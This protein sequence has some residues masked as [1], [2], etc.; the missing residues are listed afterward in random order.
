[1]SVSA[2]K[3]IKLIQTVSNR[4]GRYDGKH[5]IRIDRQKTGNPEYIPLLPIPASIVD[6]YTNDPYAYICEISI[7]LSTLIARHTFAT[8]ICL[9]NNGPVETVSRLRGYSDYTDICKGF[10]KEDQ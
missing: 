2:L 9:D 10:K 3:Y 8:T 1:M 5:W 6:R 4:E 7:E